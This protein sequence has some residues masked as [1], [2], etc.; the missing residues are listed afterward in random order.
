MIQNHFEV[1]TTKKRLSLQSHIFL[2]QGQGLG[3]LNSRR[4]REIDRI[5][6]YASVAVSY[7]FSNS[8][9]NFVELIARKNDNI[10]HSNQSNMGPTIKLMNH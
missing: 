7:G 6:F 2:G 5:K 4:D 3:G 1:T 8:D 9:K 10:L